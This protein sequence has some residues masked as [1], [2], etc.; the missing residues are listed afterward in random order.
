MYRLKTLKS[1][2]NL[3]I[4]HLYLVQG[5]DFYLFDKALSMI[6]NAC[7][8]SMPDFNYAVFDDDNFSVDK[9]TSSCEVLPMGDEYRVV[10]VKGINKI[11]E[12]DKKALYSYLDKKFDSV[13]IIFLDYFNKLDFLKD[14]SEFV[15]AKRMD[16]SLVTKIVVNELAKYKKQIGSDAVNALIDSC[17]GY[18]TKINNE[19]VKLIN[20]SGDNNIISK[21][22]VDDI[23]IKDVEYTV[24]ELTDALGRKDGDK[25]LELISLMEK[26]QGVLSLITNHFR[27]LFF[28]AISDLPNSELTSYLGVKEYAILKAKGQLSNFSKVQLRKINTILEEVDYSIKSG[29]M[30][31]TNALY[32]L[33]FNILYI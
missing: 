27:R 26:E 29:R 10:V 9:F 7:N 28:I 16:K 13:V 2:L 4:D 32:Y 5:D 18:L 24:F 1:R 12:S 23:V 11:S 6:K 3:K 15:D 25:A 21:E 20:F 33:V 30:Q 8:L 14:I 17:N 31:A 19:I 22:L